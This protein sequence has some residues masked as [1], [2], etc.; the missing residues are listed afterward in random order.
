MSSSNFGPMLSLHSLL[1]YT[2]RGSESFAAQQ[3]RFDPFQSVIAHRTE[4]TA[5]PL[6]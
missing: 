1:D 4:K 2:E 5:I 3:D 6:G